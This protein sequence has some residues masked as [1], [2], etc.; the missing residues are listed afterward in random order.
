MASC[1]A[2][3]CTNPVN[4]QPAGRGRDYCSDTCRKRAFRAR[5]HFQTVLDVAEL[6]RTA[7]DGPLLVALA[8]CETPALVKMRSALSGTAERNRRVDSAT[9]LQ[10]DRALQAE[11]SR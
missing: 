1:S 2:P 9:I 5:E 6:V 3:G 10:L 8:G 4:H 7:P 11:A